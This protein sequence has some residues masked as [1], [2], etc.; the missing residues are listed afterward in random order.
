MKLFGFFHL[1][2]IGGQ[3]RALVL[4][5]SAALQLLRAPAFLSGRPR[6]PGP[7]PGG[8]PQ[9]AGAPAPARA[10]GR[11]P[12]AAAPGGAPQLADAA[13]LLGS[14]EQAER[15]RLI[16]D[17]ARAFPKPNIETF[18]PGTANVVDDSEGQH[19]HGIRRHLGR[20]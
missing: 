19:L 17:L 2:G 13:V 16:A 5:S 20:G 12:R 3:I 7:A 18:A 4:G 1:R 14:A 15:P 10:G 11:P 9:F 6:R 8:A